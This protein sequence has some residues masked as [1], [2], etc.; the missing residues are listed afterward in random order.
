[1]PLAVLLIPARPMSQLCTI[2]TRDR[3]VLYQYV[4]LD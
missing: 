1:M 2:M 4:A 3:K